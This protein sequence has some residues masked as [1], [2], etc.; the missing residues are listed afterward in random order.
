MLGRLGQVDIN[1]LHVFRAVVE[2]GGFAAAQVVLNSTQP[3]ISNQ[4]AA[5]ETR[6]GMRLCERGRAG[7][8]LTPQGKA[9]YD[10]ALALFSA[11]DSFN[12]H[13]SALKGRVEGDLHI[14]VIDSTVTN[15]ECPVVR[16]LQRFNSRQVAVHLYLHV[17]SPL[18]IEQRVIDG[19]I[20]VGIGCF[21]NRAPGLK[22][23]KLFDE[24][25]E[26]YC[27]SSHP[28]F[29]RAGEAGPDDLGEFEFV[30]RGYF[31]V[32]HAALP[33][34][35]RITATVVTMEA[36]AILIL[37]G[38][39]LGYLPTHYAEH[40][41]RQGLMRPVAATAAQHGAVFEVIHKRGVT[42]SLAAQ[43]FLADLNAMHRHGGGPRDDLPEAAAGMAAL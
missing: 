41:T 9:V 13:V 37:T 43:A 28:L 8:R 23:R 34:G 22:Y 7:F 15:A 5:L 6:L 4:M 27:A 11:H 17:A 25:H 2:S 18:D 29:R 19:R 31:P 36:V 21:P 30:H 10:G 26:L 33:R 3:T 39:Y 42:L 20:E 24:R 38:R 12:K 35:A 32:N 1:L 14:G 40:W 16:A